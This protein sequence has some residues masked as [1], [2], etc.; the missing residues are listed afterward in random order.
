MN[1][2]ITEDIEKGYALPLPLSILDNIPNASLAPSGCHKQFTIDES[3]NLIPKYRMTHDQSFPGPSGFS[4]NLRVKK[5]LLP[6]IVYSYVLSRSLHY[7]VNTHA[8]HPSTKIF[9]CKVDLDAAFRRCTLASTTSNES[10][11]IFDNMLLIALRMTFGGSACPSLWGI[12]SETLADL[13]NALVHNTHWNH[14]ELY[15]TISDDLDHPLSLPD[16]LPFH[17]AKELSVTLPKNDL[18]Q[19]DIYIDDIIGL[20]PIFMITFKG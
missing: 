6:S 15:D 18:G 7:I 4:V 13:S 11:T 16:S 5:D 2:L 20:T 8:R 3:G 14:N 9:I 1:K 10:L 17:P 12:I 19:V